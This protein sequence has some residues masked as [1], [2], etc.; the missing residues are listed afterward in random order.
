MSHMQFVHKLRTSS[1]A[2][3]IGGV[4]EGRVCCVFAS[5]VVLAMF[6]SGDMVKGSD[7]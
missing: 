5:G 4:A 2:R 1:N 7:R 3:G 6:V